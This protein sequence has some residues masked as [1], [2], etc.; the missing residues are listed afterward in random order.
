MKQ[1]RSRVPE[2]PVPAAAQPDQ[3]A[4]PPEAILTAEQVAA[5]L[6]V[7]VSQVQR[8]NLPAVPVG[9]RRY[10]YI[11]GQVLEELRRRAE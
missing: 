1:D 11:A 8:M 6:Q 10:R 2:E 5:W 9:K 7:S 3:R 4:Y